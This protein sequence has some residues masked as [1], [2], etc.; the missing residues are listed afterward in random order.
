MS[1]SIHKFPDKLMIRDIYNG[2]YNTPDLAVVKPHFGVADGTV[3]GVY[4]LKEI[5]VARSVVTYEAPKETE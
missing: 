4:V 2:A 1:E 3:V 5:R